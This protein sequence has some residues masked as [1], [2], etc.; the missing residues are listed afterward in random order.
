[1]KKILDSY[2]VGTG[3]TIGF[4]LAVFLYEWDLGGRLGEIFLMNANN[5]GLM[6]AS[7]L[8]YL[9]YLQITT[10]IGKWSWAFTILFIV[11]LFASAS[12]GA[13]MFAAVS[14]L[15]LIWMQRNWSA[16]LGLSLLIILT[17]FSLISFFHF[18]GGFSEHLLKGIDLH[19]RSFSLEQASVLRLSL[20]QR[21]ISLLE[22]NFFNGI[23]WTNFEYYSGTFSYSA[24]RTL[25]AHNMYLQ[26][27][28][29]L[30]ILGL[31]ALVAWQT[32]LFLKLIKSKRNLGLA[33]FLGFALFGFTHG[34]FLSGEIA[35]FYGMALGIIQLRS[36][37]QPLKYPWRYSFYKLNSG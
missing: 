22:S 5:V 16:I 28:V 19:A 13:I 21:G 24:E 8:L 34:N 14:I 15:C 4:M 36:V 20:L 29:E 23:G 27:A 26:I 30:G 3:L 32:A 10:R 11:A 35:S 6:A 25:P 2:L 1:M 33:A 9:V 7:C 17:I 12:R 31:F 18:E 37:N